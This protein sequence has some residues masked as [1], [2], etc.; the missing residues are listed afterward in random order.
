M[1]LSTPSLLTG[2]AAPAAPTRRSPAARRTALLVR[3]AANKDKEAQPQATASTRREL[4]LNS[5]GML[6]LGAM[7]NFG[8]APRPSSIGLQ[9][10]NGVKTLGLCP[11][12]PNCISTAEEANDPAHYVPQWTYNPEEGRGR[13]KPVD[14]KQA[15]K[16]LKEVVE[17]IHPDKYSPKV[18]KQTGDYLYAEFESPTFG[19]IDDVEFYFPPGDKRSLVEYRSASRIGD[20]DFDINRKRIKA[21]REALQKK[22]WKSIGY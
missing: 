12:N 2:I 15:M 5:T 13:K 7:F 11:P 9:E 21:I 18:V 3:A 1:S 22:G 6:T 8:A 10:F 4:L 19:F 14:Q 16:E 17:S 20:S